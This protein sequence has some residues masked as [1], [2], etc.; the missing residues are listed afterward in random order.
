[1]PNTRFQ[2]DY[3]V[4]DAV[5]ADFHGAQI[6]GVIE[7]KRDDA[8]LVRLAQPWTDETGEATDSA[9]L[10]PGRLSPQLG[11]A[12]GEQALPAPE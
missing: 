6:P 2:H 9:W 10:S 4:G 3:Q 7:D 12:G 11:Q 5:L 1:M 8:L